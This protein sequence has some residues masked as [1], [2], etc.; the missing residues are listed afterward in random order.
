M[1]QFVL[2]N[3]TNVRPEVDL[4]AALEINVDDILDDEEQYFQMQMSQL[5]G[6]T[7]ASQSMLHA[8]SPLEAELALYTNDKNPVRHT[9]DILLWWSQHQQVYPLLCKAAKKYLAVQATSCAVERTFSTSG[10]TVTSRRTLLMTK[11]VEMLVY[12]KENIPKV[13]MTGLILSNDKEQFNEEDAKKN[14]HDESDDF[15]EA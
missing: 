2:D 8:Q 13:P 4:N 1:S 15:F 6:E 5:T 11:N 3:E 12:C 7:Q 9:V 10:N 14:P